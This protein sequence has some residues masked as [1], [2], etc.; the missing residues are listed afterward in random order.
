M[1]ETECKELGSDCTC[2]R[3]EGNG[4][5]F[6]SIVSSYSFGI[7]SSPD[8]KEKQQNYTILMEENTT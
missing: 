6:A 4:D 7:S 8:W 1:D 5:K 2:G 3:E